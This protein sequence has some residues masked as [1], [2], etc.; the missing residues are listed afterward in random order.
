MR[1]ELI[2]GGPGLRVVLYL[3]QSDREQRLSI[4]QQRQ[5]CRAYAQ[6]RGWVIVA[7]YI[8]NGKSGSKEVAKRTQWHR[9][10]ASPSP[11]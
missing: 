5:E 2:I 1:N 8:D 9:L 6:S 4:E 3:R 7:E 10:I 11:R